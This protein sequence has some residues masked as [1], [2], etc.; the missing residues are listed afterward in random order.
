VHGT[1]GF[2]GQE[3]P[4]S[5]KESLR[6][7]LTSIVDN[8]SIEDP[9]MG[10]TQSILIRQAQVRLLGVTDTVIAAQLHFAQRSLARDRYVVSVEMEEEEGEICNN[11]N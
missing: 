8:R 3:R 11:D 5:I 9:S 4:T 10:L 2:V 6:D 7:S 1:F